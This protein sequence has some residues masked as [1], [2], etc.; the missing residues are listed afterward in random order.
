MRPHSHREAPRAAGHDLRWYLGHTP[1]SALAKQP[2]TVAPHDDVE[3]LITVLLGRGLDCVAVV[4]PHH[5]PLGMVYA[6]DL[7]RHLDAGADCGE[8]AEEALPLDGE[9][10]SGFHVYALA[11]THATDLMRPV[12][13]TV[14][15]TRSIWAAAWQLG[16]EQATWAPV[17]SKRGKLVG[18]LSAVDV[19]RWIVAASGALPEPGT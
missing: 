11:H 4:D 15:E 18:M 7:L 1:A 6:L 10:R 14:V 13:L 8:P 2:I 17:V 3:T 5:E 16:A 12:G 19:L 9:L